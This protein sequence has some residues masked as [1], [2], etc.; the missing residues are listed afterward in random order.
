MQTIQFTP[1]SQRKYDAYKQ[2]THQNNNTY[3]KYTPMHAHHIKFHDIHSCTTFDPSWFRY[4]LYHNIPLHYWVVT[5]YN[6]AS[7]AFTISHKYLITEYTTQ[8]T[9]ITITHSHTHSRETFDPSWFRY[10][11]YHNTP[12]HQR[13]IADHNSPPNTLVISH[14]HLN[15]KYT[16]QHTHPSPSHTW[17][18]PCTQHFCPIQIL[19]HIAAPWTIASQC[20]HTLYQRHQ[21]IC[22]IS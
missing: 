9:P 11:L 2:T 7:N 12:L 20:C 6:R 3:R 21:C 14:K 19:L 8:S 1:A 10:A 16:T 17:P 13:L 22:N 5:D 15:T 18:H 4:A